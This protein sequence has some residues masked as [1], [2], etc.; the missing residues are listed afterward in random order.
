VEIYIDGV[1]AG[2][3]LVDENSSS[4][5]SN[6]ANKA[7]SI[8][9]S[10][11][12]NAYIANIDDIR[13][14]DVARSMAQIR[15]NHNRQLTGNEQGLQ[16]YFPL[17]NDNIAGEAVYD[18]VGNISNTSFVNTVNW[19]A[20]NAPAFDFDQII[21]DIPLDAVQLNPVANKIV[22]KPN[23]NF[24]ASYLEGAT[25]TASVT[26]VRAANGNAAENKSWTFTMNQNP[27]GWVVA[28]HA[29]AADIN[30][31]E[32]DF[33]LQFHNGGAGTASYDPFNWPS[34]L[35]ANRLFGTVPVTQGSPVSLPGSNTHT[36]NMKAQLGS[37]DNYTKET[38]YMRT[39]NASGFVSGYE[40]LILEIVKIGSTARITVTSPSGISESEIKESKS[41]VIENLAEQVSLE[42]NYPNPF[43]RETSFVYQLPESMSVAFNIYDQLGRK[44]QTLFS[45]KQDAGKYEFSWNRQGLA[46]RDLPKGVYVY[47]LVTPEKVI[48]KKMILN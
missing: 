22:L 26:N 9:K 28:N 31:S 33:D 18:F 3:G 24:P 8:G 44:V 12:E 2:S 17:E 29:Q 13:V 47:E 25:L 32:V 21:H 42:Q 45:G 39:Y 16:I 34:W 7:W 15:D 14:W 36:L 38:I 19:A 10:N 40:A 37:L 43:G 30:A 6:Q 27:V 20:N 23:V 1:L 46:G 5:L 48:R 11:L 35:T 4:L 41:E